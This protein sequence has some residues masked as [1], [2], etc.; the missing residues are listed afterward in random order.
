MTPY[1]Q[2]SL[3]QLALMK[4]CCQIVYIFT[5]DV[6]GLVTILGLTLKPDSLHVDTIALM[7][8]LAL[9][10]ASQAGG[11]VILQVE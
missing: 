2:W 9:G 11:E 3:R 4:I 5:Q 6:Y 10:A 1:I 8:L 7:L